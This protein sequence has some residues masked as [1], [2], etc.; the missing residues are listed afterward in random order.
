MMVSE[1]AIEEQKIKAIRKSSRI[2]KYLRN[3]G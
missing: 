2:L 1:C 3:L